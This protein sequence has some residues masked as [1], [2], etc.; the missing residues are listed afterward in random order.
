MELNNFISIYDDILLPKHLGKLQKVCK[1]FDWYEG[2]VGKGTINKNI[3]KVKI[4]DLSN[5][6]DSMTNV[7]WHNV[8]QH[9]FESYLIEYVKSRDIKLMNSSRLETIQVLKYNESDY[10][11]W[12]YD[13][14]P[15]IH[16]TFSCIF[17]LNEDYEGGELCFR[18]PDGTGEFAIPKKENR[19]IIWPSSFL[20]PHTV[21]PIK[22]GEKYSIVSWTQ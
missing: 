19:M 8:M 21:K 13:S 14:S 15:R 16:R 9:I 10:Y 5:C 4:C 6:S 18:N 11:T 20:Y 3:R 22:S 12:H 1:S 7:H 17:F 2:T